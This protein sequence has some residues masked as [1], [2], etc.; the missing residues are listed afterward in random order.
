M[1]MHWITSSAAAVT[2]ATFMSAAPAQAA[3]MPRIHT[4]ARFCSTLTVQLA[5]ISVPP[6]PASWV[7][8]RNIMTL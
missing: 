1:N 2:V 6:V 4:V 7:P 5:F 3:M 8:K